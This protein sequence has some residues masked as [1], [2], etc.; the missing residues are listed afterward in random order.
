MINSVE[1]AEPVAR[2]IRL[3][4]PRAIAGFANLEVRA[5]ADLE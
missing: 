1:N 5:A 3:S 2:A 4:S